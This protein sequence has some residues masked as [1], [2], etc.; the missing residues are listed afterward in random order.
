MY[1]DFLHPPQKQLLLLNIRICRPYTTNCCSPS[2]SSS[3][4]SCSCY[5][6]LPVADAIRTAV[7]I[8]P[9]AAALAH[10]PYLKLMYYEL[11]H[12]QQQQQQQLLLL[13]ANVQQP[14]SKPLKANL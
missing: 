13:H 14:T 2:S 7:I 9:A 12:P 8:S 6:F 10:Y 5:T 4:S 11:L 3:S 1:Y